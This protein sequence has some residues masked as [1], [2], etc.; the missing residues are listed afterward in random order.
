M[1]VFH[2]NVEMTVQV[3]SRGSLQ[4]DSICN[5]VSIW[6][7]EMGYHLAIIVRPSKLPQKQGA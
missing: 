2:T 3:A 7:W 5:Y 4:I 1:S 6:L